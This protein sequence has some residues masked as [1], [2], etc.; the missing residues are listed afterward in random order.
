VKDAIGQQLSR[1]SDA[2]HRLLSIASV[3]G[4]GFEFGA[5]ERVTDSR[6]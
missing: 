1:L 2:C 6:E 5:L 3:M 4:R